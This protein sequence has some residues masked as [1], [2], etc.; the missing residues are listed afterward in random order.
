MSSFACVAEARALHG[1][2]RHA[3]APTLAR[4]HELGCAAPPAPLPFPP[5][6]HPSSTSTRASFAPFP[7]RANWV[8][9]PP[10]P[11]PPSLSAPTAAPPAVSYT[12][13]KR[14]RPAAPSSS[15]SAASTS[16]PAA[17]TAPVVASALSN[18]VT[19]TAPSSSAT[20]AGT[21]ASTATEEVVKRKKPASVQSFG[22]Q[23][24]LDPYPFPN[25]LHPAFARVSLDIITQLFPFV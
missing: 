12:P 1:T 24:E 5:S 17:A 10:P 21:V 3:V 15:S 6:V 20:S 11:P 2:G 19:S 7:T 22:T 4:A 8:P 25:L 23:R 13:S 9:P 14:P 16:A 18:I